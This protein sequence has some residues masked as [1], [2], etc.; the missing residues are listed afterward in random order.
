VKPKK[1][2]FTYGTCGYSRT[3]PRQVSAAMKAINIVVPFE[4]ALKLGLAI[5][6]CCRELNTYDRSTKRGRDAALLL[7]VFLDSRRI[8]VN[9]DRV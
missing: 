8:A 2:K 6:E 7:T 9:E 3:S 1:K 5:D 4:E